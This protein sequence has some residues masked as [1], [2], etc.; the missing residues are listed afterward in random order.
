MKGWAYLKQSLESV[1][2]DVIE[3]TSEENTDSAPHIIIGM[4]SFIH[5]FIPI[6]RKKHRNFYQILAKIHKRIFHLRATANF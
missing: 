4:E 2:F 1:G 3:R 5:L 6:I